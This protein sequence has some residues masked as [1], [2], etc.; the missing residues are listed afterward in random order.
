MSDFNPITMFAITSEMF[1]IWLWLLIVLG[2]VAIALHIGGWVSSKRLTAGNFRISVVAGLVVA[3]VAALMLPGLTQ[4]S[5][6]LLNG[7]A[8]VIGLVLF[9]AAIGFG[10]AVTLSGVLRWAR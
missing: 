10:L 2:L 6:G 8:D 5:L 7:M 3:I 4:S 1:G 9:A